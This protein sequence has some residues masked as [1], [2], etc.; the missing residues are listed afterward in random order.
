MGIKTFS[1]F[2]FGHTI[3]TDNQ[4]IDFSEGGPEIT[5]VIK[6]GSFSLEDFVNEVAVAINN[7]G[8]QEYTATLDRSTRKITIAAP[9]NFELLPTTGTTSS[10]SAYPLM[11]F[12]ADRSG[13][14][15]YEGENASGSFYEPQNLLQ[16]FV[17]FDINVK[18]IS[19][20][21]RQ[22]ANGQ[23][24]VVSYG[25][26]EFMECNISPITDIIPQ[27]YIT[28]NANALSESVVFLDYCTTKAPIEFVPDVTVPATFQKCLLESTR[29]SKQGVDFKI[30][31][32]FQKQLFGYFE[33][34]LLTFRGLT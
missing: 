33:S 18:T 32:M 7:A 10:I 8:G 28:S 5:A 25:K 21:V 9:G 34:G 19:P 12:V 16:K 31:E 24:E 2:T 14:N 20:T 30:K 23:V 6:V 22:T 29:E 15:S 17:D 26:V 4:N 11:G 27:L 1:G 3:T 13:S